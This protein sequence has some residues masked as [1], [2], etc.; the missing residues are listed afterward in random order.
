MPNG[1]PRQW[2]EWE[3]QEIMEIQDMLHGPVGIPSVLL[4]WGKQGSGKTM[5]MVW[6]GYK[7]RKY[8]GMPTVIDSPYMK[9]AYGTYTLMTDK[10]FIKEQMKIKLMVDL[11]EK[12]GRSAELE[13]EDL[14]IKLFRAAVLWDEAYSK[15]SVHQ[16]ADKIA[17]LYNFQ[18]LQYRHNQCV[19]CIVSPDPNQINRQYSSKFA[20]HEVS[21]TYHENYRGTGE[22]YST[23]MIYN[24]TTKQF[25]QKELRVLKWGKL[26]KTGGVITPKVSFKKFKSA[27]LDE[28]DELEILQWV[29]VK[30]GELNEHTT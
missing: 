11:Y 9:P 27:D 6:L 3:V 23:Y 15:I 14:G 5:F 12:V 16:T 10:D 24:R 26:F 28:I 22:P 2:A 29:E 25:Y 7:L 8:F 18:V 13:W 21:C 30:K 19:I 17:Q 20:T 1:E 4:L